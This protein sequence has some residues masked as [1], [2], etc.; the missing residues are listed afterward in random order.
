[1]RIFI[2][3]GLVVAMLA[4]CAGTPIAQ[5]DNY[6][7]CQELAHN[8]PRTTGKRV[9][10]GVMTLG[11]SEIGEAVDA[12]D[13]EEIRMEMR[14]RGLSACDSRTQ[15]AFE[16]AKIYPNQTTPEFKTCVLTTTNTIEARIASDRAAAEAAAARAAAYQAA[17]DA[18]KAEKSTSKYVP[19]YNY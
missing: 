3:S 7:L 14:K 18:K 9:A 13:V 10:M 17:Q 8:L 11:L 16:C 12:K 4:G 5:M 1:M 2:V 6:N 19:Q 15:A